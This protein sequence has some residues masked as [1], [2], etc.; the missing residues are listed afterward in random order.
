V[1]A[2]VGISAV[3]CAAPALAYRPFDGTYA[4]VADFG[5]VEIELQPIGSMRAGSTTK[6]IS[7][8]VLNFGFADRWELVLQGTAQPPS[9]AE[10]P[11]VYPMLPS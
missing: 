1:G 3:F 10:V 8:S 4:A 9:Q 6:G 5:E 11:S 7:D 2:A